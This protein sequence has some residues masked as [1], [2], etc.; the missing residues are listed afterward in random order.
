MICLLQNYITFALLRF[1]YIGLSLESLSYVKFSR[2][3]Y[4]IL[5]DGD[6]PPISILSSERLY[7]LEIVKT[8]WGGGLSMCKNDN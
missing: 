1:S 2:N 7:Y 3:C 8:W 5:S 4:S 6:Y